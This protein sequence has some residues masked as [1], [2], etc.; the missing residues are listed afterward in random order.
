MQI[1]GDDK[2]RYFQN[3]FKTTEMWYQLTFEA[4]CR[5]SETSDFFLFFLSEEEELALECWRLRCQIDINYT[6]IV[7]KSGFT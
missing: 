3:I 5:K 1:V 2:T 4:Q 6:L 7:I